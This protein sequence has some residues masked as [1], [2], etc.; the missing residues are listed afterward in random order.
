MNL[1]RLWCVFGCGAIAWR[2]ATERRCYAAD[3]CA[4]TEK[5][6]F[7]WQNNWDGQEN[8]RGEKGAIRHIILIREAK[9][10]PHVWDKNLTFEGRMQASQL[11][12][13]LDGFAKDLNLP[14]TKVVRSSMVRARETC[15][16]ALENIPPEVACPCPVE[17]GL[18]EE[19]PPYRHEPPDLEYKPSTFNIATTTERLDKA[20][21]KHFFR[22]QKGQSIELYFLHANVIRYIVCKLMQF[23]L[24]SWM[25]FSLKHCSI[26]HL[27]IRYNGWV[28]LYAF[29]DTGWMKAENITS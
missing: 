26:T 6:V 15:K 8:N 19:G 11:G 27:Q 28:L 21:E 24:H 20:I 13:Y 29:G 14:I 23:P 5:K 17:E 22:P 7:P 2:R 3:I 10:D 9:F 16:T 25:R 18:F 4:S 1:G 12:K